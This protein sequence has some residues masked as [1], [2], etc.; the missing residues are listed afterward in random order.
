MIGHTPLYNNNNDDEKQISKKFTK[1]AVQ[2]TALTTVLN[3]TVFLFCFYGDLLYMYNIKHIICLSSDCMLQTLGNS[4][5]NKT[6]LEFLTCN[7]FTL[8]KT[9]HKLLKQ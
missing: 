1:Y 7:N 2:C 3:I 8:H 5:E 4:R 6:A 9:S